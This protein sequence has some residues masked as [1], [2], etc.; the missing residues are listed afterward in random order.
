LV[1]GVARVQNVEVDHNQPGRPARDA[2]VER[3]PGRPRGADP[4]GVDGGALQK[5]LRYQLGLSWAKIV[6]AG[7]NQATLANTY[8]RLTGR[9]TAYA[10]FKA[11]ADRHW[12]AAHPSGIVGTDNAF[13]VADGLELWHD[14]KS[15]GGIVESAPVSVSWG[16]SRFDTFAI[17]TDSALYH[18][19]YDGTSWGGWESL[20][21]ICQSSPSVVSW[22]PGRRDI[23]V[24]GTDSGLYHRWWDG[25]HWGGFEGLGGVLTSQPTAVS[26]APDRIDV[27]ALGEDNA[28]WHR[29]WDG[30]AWGGWESLGGILMGKVAA[31]C[32]GPNRIDLFGVGTDHALYHRWWDGHAWGGWESLGGILTPTGG[33]L[34]GR[35]TTRRL[36]PR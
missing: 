16:P 12:P 36:R 13:P 4:A 10:D 15:L 23:F 32:W 28:C 25:A 8:Q 21:G 29:W 14:W 30:H 9:T 17:G 34:L 11:F 1:G 2:D 27:F 22:E 6:K 35:R 20:G 7:K 5:Y 26:W 19:W 31:A 24:V 3:G 33:C 18:R